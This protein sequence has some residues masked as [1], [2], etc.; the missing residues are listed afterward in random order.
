MS[1]K[2]IGRL[3]RKMIT[4]MKNHHRMPKQMPDA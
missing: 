2:N 4:F 3:S 1:S